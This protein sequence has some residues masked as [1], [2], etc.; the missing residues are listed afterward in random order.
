MVLEQSACF[1]NERERE[2]RFLCA[3]S[4]S[5]CSPCLN[6]DASESK[7][8]EEGRGAQKA[9]PAPLFQGANIASDKLVGKSTQGK[10]IYRRRFC[11]RTEERG[12]RGNEKKKK[13][14][15]QSWCVVQCHTERWDRECGCS[16]ECVYVCACGT[17]VSEKQTQV[18]KFWAFYNS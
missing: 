6:F 11:Q 16:C 2:G 15:H 10:R 1:R 8:A 18:I 13:P 9:T 5:S 12:R 17:F 14:G 4:S 3:S 7:E